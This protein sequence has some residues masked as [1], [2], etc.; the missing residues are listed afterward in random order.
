MAFYPF[1]PD[2][3]VVPGEIVSEHMEFMGMNQAE[4]ARRCGRSAKLISE[5]VNGK[6]PIEPETAL[7][8]EKV[9]GLDANIWLN[10]EASYRLFLA[11]EAEARAAS[12]AEEWARQFPVSK[13]AARGMIDA[14]RSSADKVEQLLTFFGVA[15]V[16]AWNRRYAEAHV[17]YRHS[18][19]FKSKAPAFA[20][21]LRLG[22]LQSL[23]TQCDHFDDQRFRSVLARIRGLTRVPLNDALQEAARLCR[24]A[25]VAL[26]VVPLLPHT[27]LS[28]A[29]RWVGPHKAVIQLSGR[30]KTNDHIWF[31]FFHEA[32]HLIL[33]R[34]KNRSSIFLDEAVL[35]N[36][37]E[38]ERQANE[39]A[40]DFLIP[41][42]VWQ[43]FILAGEFVEASVSSFAADIGVA[44]GIVVGRLQYER[45]ISK[46]LLNH[47]KAKAELLES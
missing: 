39:W 32:A 29:A 14:P 37:C 46:S 25:G 22:E 24:E 33:H 36:G 5:I 13:L 8:F 19:S 45:F 6:A 28:G 23:E 21:W 17:A 38:Q 41:Q 40:G 3:T 20:T 43:D 42:D 44:P 12:D 26:V 9:L 47:L 1:Q 10:L 35:K 18:P 2:Y 7:Q 31:T 11:R 27:H 34:V 4:L 15:S 30:H 16:E